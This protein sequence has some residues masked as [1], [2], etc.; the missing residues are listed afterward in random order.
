MDWEI[1]EKPEGRDYVPLL[2]VSAQAVLVELLSG[3]LSTT[4]TMR[5]PGARTM[6]LKKSEFPAETSLTTAVVFQEPEPSQ[7]ADCSG[8]R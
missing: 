4:T 5:S 7:T 2:R 6:K 1:D 8:P 3:S